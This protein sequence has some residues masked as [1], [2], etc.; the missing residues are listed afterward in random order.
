MLNAEKRFY[1]KKDPVLW[2][3][4]VY[5]SNLRVQYYNIRLKSERH[6]VNAKD[7]LQDI[8]GKVNEDSKTILRK[9]TKNLESSFKRPL[10]TTT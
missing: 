5:L 6:I 3:P 2:T 10:K 7:R 4:A 8:V 1:K 9:N